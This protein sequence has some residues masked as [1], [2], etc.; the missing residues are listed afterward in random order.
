MSL[1]ILNFI[2]LPVMILIGLIIWIALSG[3]GLYF[4]WRNY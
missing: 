4:I 1:V 2:I 3:I